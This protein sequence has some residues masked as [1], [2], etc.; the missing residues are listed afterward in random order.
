FD[1]P[2]GCRGSAADAAG[3]RKLCGGG[4]LQ[5]HFRTWIGRAGRRA[6]ANA[7]IADGGWQA[8]CAGGAAQSLPA[9]QLSERSGLPS[10][11][12][13]GGSVR[14]WGGESAVGKKRYPRASSGPD[15]GRVKVW[16]GNK[17]A[18]GACG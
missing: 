2:A 5:R 13:L 17:V 3:L 14:D 1:V 10:Y 12:Q 6:R 15:P 4:F 16:R 9:A 11:V 8:G 18:G 7:R